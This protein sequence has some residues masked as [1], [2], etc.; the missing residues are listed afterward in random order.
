[1]S[2]TTHSDDYWDYD[3]P[4]EWQKHFPAAAGLCQSPIDIDAHKTI[5]H[6]YP[7]FVFS[8]KYHSNELFKLINTGHQVAATLADHTYG[9]SEKDLWFNGSG[10]TG[11]FYFVNFHLHWGRDDRH[12]SEHEIDG[13]QYPAE[14]HVVFKNQETGQLAVFAYIFTVCNQTQKGNKEWEKYCDAASQLTNQNDTIQCMFDLSQLMQ[15][16]DR[17]FFRYTG[18]LTTPPCTE[19]V[20]WTIFIQKIAIKEESL[21]QLRQ[22]LMRK[23]YRPIQPLNNRTV[24]RNY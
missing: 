2:C 23:V 10:L 22:N 1:M 4:S 8:D 18:S 19:G 17:Q 20:I 13:Y 6:H 15:A 12:G 7:P 16:N 3:N 11:R 14:A 21:N 5:P 9:Q 24:F